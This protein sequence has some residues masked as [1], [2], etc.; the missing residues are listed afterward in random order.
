MGTKSEFGT[1]LSLDIDGVLG[2]HFTQRFHSF[3]NAM[4]R[5]LRHNFMA[6]FPM[7]S[8][9]DLTPLSAREI[10]KAGKVLPSCTYRYVQVA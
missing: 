7:K 4:C 9:Q 6:S 5:H 3:L 8:V 1:L 2:V 10:S